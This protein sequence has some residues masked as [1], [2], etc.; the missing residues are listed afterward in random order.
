[1]E[2]LVTELKGK[3]NV[4]KGKAQQ[5]WA[6]VN[7]NDFDENEDKDSFIDK[8]DRKTDGARE[9]IEEWYDRQI[10]RSENW[11]L[12]LKGEWN[13]LKGRAQQKWAD[14]SED[15]LDNDQNE[16]D[17]DSFIDK[18]VAK[19]NETKEDVENWFDKQFNKK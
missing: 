7:E 2:N 10:E 15:D 3:W 6:E 12:K 8:M 17:R 4:L 19:T 14:L 5:K 9:N 13:E 1:M 11:R 16:Y 18:V